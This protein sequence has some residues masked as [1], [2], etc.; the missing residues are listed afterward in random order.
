MK[1][2]LLLLLLL[3]CRIHAQEQFAVYFDLDKDVPTDASIRKL[4]QWTAQY[5]NAEIVNVLGY[6]DS[7]GTVPYNK[8]LSQR[9]ADFVLGILNAQ[10]LK[11]A[12]GA[13]AKGEGETTAFSENNTT[14]RLVII[15]YLESKN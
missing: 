13:V 6:A 2:F 3:S 8:E 15:H 5:K 7:I 4:E 1:I 11:F 14:D 12:V 9:R 10:G